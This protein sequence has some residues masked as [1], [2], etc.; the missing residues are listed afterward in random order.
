MCVCVCNVGL[1]IWFLWFELLVI[2]L[3][4]DFRFSV[5]SDSQLRRS[6]QRVEVYC[7]ITVSRFANTS[8]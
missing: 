7:Y 4:V 1:A 8:F 6:P 2:I 3:L 5:V